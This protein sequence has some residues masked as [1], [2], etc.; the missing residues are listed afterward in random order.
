MRAAVHEFCENGFERAKII[1]IAKNAG[2]AKGSIHQYFKDKKEL[3]VYCAEWGLEVF[4]KKIDGR[5]PMGD[6]DVFEYF[7]DTTA[8]AEVLRE[9]HELF[10]FMR[11]VFN[12]PGLLD[13]SM[14]HMYNVGDTYT[15]KLIQ[16]GKDRGTVR[17]D[18]DDAMLMEYFSAVTNHFSQRWVRLYIGQTGE[19]RPET[20]QVMKNE[21]DQMLKLLKKGM[22]ESL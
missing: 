8:Q 9:E 20:E 12:E 7:K 22:G 13:E 17:K 5:I 11:V 10:M 1:D 18:I 14:K 16:N 6:M 3:F 21:L 2:V 4:M 19:P 15:K